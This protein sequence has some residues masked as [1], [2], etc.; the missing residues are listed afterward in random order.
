MPTEK[1]HTSFRKSKTISYCMP[2]RLK[3]PKI[4]EKYL[5]Y[6]VSEKQTLLKTKPQGHMELTMNQVVSISVLC[7]SHKSISV[8]IMNLLAC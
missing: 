2:N 7:L 3:T 5:T 8:F 1:F 4:C 6:S